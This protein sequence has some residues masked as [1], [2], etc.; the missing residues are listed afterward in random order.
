MWNC[1]IV[2][3]RSLNTEMKPERDFDRGKIVT[4]RSFLKN[5]ETAILTCLFVNMLGL[6]FCWLHQI[7]SFKHHSGS[8]ALPMA[9]LQQCCTLGVPATTLPPPHHPTL[10]AGLAPGSWHH[11][12][13]FV[14]RKTLFV[15]VNKYRST[16]VR[17]K[18]L[19]CGLHEALLQ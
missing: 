2:A 1:N 5:L 11:T 6:G 7:I 15:Y 8:R 9:Q 17:V 12:N 10:V 19:A 18:H 13:I 3:F 14:T 16:R 4:P